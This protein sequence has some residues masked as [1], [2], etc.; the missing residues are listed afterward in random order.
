MAPP[1]QLPLAQDLQITMDTQV[2]TQHHSVYVKKK[3]QI[4][5]GNSQD[6]LRMDSTWTVEH[7]ESYYRS[8]FL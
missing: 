4:D 2:R 5:E 8:A 7:P 1:A 3:E 6:S